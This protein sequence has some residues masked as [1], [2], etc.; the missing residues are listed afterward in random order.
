MERLLEAAEL[1]EEQ[2]KKLEREFSRQY[3]LITRDD[4]LETVAEDIV[5]HFMGRGYRGKAMVVCI[6]KATAIR[7]Y[8]K[9]QNHWKKH[10]E[11]TKSNLFSAPEERQEALQNKLKYMQETDM[12]VVVSQSQ[13]EIEEMEK[14][15]LEIRPHRKRIVSE[16]LDPL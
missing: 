11:A 5:N 2:E 14:K 6:D 12:A 13:N 10:L 4:R 8:D 3:H 7:M 15:G 16:D 1:D 9:V